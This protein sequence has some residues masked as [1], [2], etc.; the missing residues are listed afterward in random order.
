MF[1]NRQ[2]V[3]V[4]VEF[5]RRGASR[6]ALQRATREGQALLD[7]FELRSLVVADSAVGGVTDG[8]HLLGFGLN[9]SSCIT[10]T[11]EQ[12]LPLVLRHFLDGG[13]E[14]DFRSVKV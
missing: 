7:S 8:H 5:P 9:L 13:V 6:A 10:P 4:S 3:I 12:G 11:V 1:Q 14:G 2:R